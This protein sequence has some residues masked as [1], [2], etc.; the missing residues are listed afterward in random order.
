MGPRKQASPGDDV[1]VVDPNRI[2]FRGPTVWLLL[3]IAV[4]G[5]LGYA[6]FDNAIDTIQNTIVRDAVNHEKDREAIVMSIREVRDE[7][8]KLI[9]DTVATRQ[10][11]AWIELFRSAN[12]AKFPDLVVPDLPR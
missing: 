5:A 7:V 1:L 11:Q 2:G 10:A 12:K 9:V 3:I 4:G 6:R 8:R